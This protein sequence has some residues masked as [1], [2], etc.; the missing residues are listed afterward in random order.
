MAR[1]I[2]DIKS[3]SENVKEIFAATYAQR[4]TEFLSSFTLSNDEIM[5]IHNLT[6]SNNS[7]SQMKNRDFL[8]RVIT[9]QKGPFNDEVI[10]SFTKLVDGE[11]L[12]KLIKNSDK[13]LSDKTRYEWI[14]KAITV[15][16]QFNRFVES[17]QST[18]LGFDLDKEPWKRA[19]MLGVF[20]DR[21]Q[22]YILNNIEEF[23]AYLDTMSENELY[24]FYMEAN[25]DNVFETVRF[26]IWFPYPRTTAKIIEHY[27]NNG[28]T[29]WL[30]EK[31]AQHPNCPLEIQ[32]KMYKETKDTAFLPEDARNLFTF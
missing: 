19:F 31:M 28:T 29:K 4:T 20:T 11:I 9:G 17:G 23:R 15:R 32:L 16:R 8:F 7:K 26:K 27:Y 3:D 6:M 25:T 22:T 10:K 2:E 21:K 13:T 30:A 14:K 24:D 18:L 12:F 5:E 1:T